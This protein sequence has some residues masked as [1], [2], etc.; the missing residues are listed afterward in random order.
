MN[1]SAAALLDDLE[2]ILPD[3]LDYERD[4]L[5]AEIRIRFQD[6]GVEPEP[7]YEKP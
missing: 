3:L 7:Y 5:S 2:A 1:P 4:E 6:V